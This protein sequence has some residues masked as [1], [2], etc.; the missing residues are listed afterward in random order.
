MNLINKIA[1]G[2]FIISCILRYLGV[3]MKCEEKCDEI[4]E[5]MFIIVI[6]LVIIGGGFK[7][8]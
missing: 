8:G 3:F 7:F 4:A 2:L 6:I 5:Y 1:I